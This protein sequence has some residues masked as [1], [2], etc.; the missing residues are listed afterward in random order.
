MGINTIKKEAPPGLPEGRSRKK[1]I[2]LDNKLKTVLKNQGG[3]L[4]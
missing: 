3:F 1:Y 4:L 2:K